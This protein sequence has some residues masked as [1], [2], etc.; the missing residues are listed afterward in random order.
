ME[1]KGFLRL[2]PLAFLL[3]MIFELVVMQT[4]SEPYPAVIFP[5]FQHSSHEDS[6][7]TARFRLVAYGPEEKKTIIDHTEIFDFAPSM[8]GF[9]MLLNMSAKS[10]D[11]M[12][13]V[14]E[15]TEKAYWKQLLLSRRTRAIEKSEQQYDDALLWLQERADKLAYMP[16]DS[17]VV[18]QHQYTMNWQQ[19]SMDTNIITFKTFVFSQTSN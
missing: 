16:V 6:L 4:V 11:A 1:R 13:K 3:F 7:K 12:E 17:L 15:G 9:F 8:T 19:N 2:I 14:A 10:P 18:Q 5:P